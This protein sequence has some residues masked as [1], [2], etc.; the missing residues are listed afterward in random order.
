MTICFPG[1]N[2]RNVAYHAQLLILTV[3][4]RRFNSCSIKEKSFKI[5]IYEM[6]LVQTNSLSRVS[7][8]RPFI[9]A[10]GV[11]GPIVNL[12]CTLLLLLFSNNSNSFNVANPY[13]S[14]RNALEVRRENVIRR[15]ISPNNLI[16]TNSTVYS[17]FTPPIHPTFSVHVLCMFDHIFTH[18]TIFVR[19]ISLLQHVFNQFVFHL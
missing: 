4:C 16:C 19:F 17:A 14:T 5:T 9:F 18:P 13:Q 1:Q 10:T 6:S 8:K 3:L 11:P 2:R 15:I 12:L 7:L